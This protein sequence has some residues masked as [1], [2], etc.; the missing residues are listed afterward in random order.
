MRPRGP[1]AL[2]QTLI[3]NVERVV[4]YHIADVQL[5]GLTAADRARLQTHLEARFKIWVNTWIMPELKILQRKTTRKA[6]KHDGT[7]RE[8]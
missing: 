7:S 1:A 6:P 3:N 5:P 4:P 8:T 2:V